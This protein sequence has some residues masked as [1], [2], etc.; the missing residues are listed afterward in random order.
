MV[1][2][3]PWDPLLATAIL[4]AVAAVPIAVKIGLEIQQKRTRRLR[5]EFGPGYDAAV[6]EHG[7]WRK[8]EAALIRQRKDSSGE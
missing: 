4:L 8:A 5:E 3:N 2:A 7:D 6:R 1:D